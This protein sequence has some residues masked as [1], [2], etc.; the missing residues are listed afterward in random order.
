MNF[1]KISALV[2][3][4]MI[5]IRKS[6]WRLVEIF[7]FP[8]T[9]I[10]IWGFFAAYS[11][12]IAFEAGIF[13]LIVN[14]F[15]NFAYV[16][17]STINI[18]LMD[19]SWNGSLKQMFLSGISEIE[20]I[21]ARIITSSIVSSIVLTL[22]LSVAYLFIGSDL[23]SG[24]AIAVISLLTL[25]T[26]MAMGVL[27]GSLIIVLG[28]GYGFLAWT[29]LQAFI[30]LSAPFFPKEMFPIPLRYVT[31]VM[32]YTHIFEAARNLGTG[33]PVFFGSAILVTVAYSILVW[34][35]YVYFFRLARKNGKLVRLG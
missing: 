8:V 14:V 2:Y 35:F 7:Y 12:S 30:L 9:T 29:A 26:S 10:I 5:V 20:Y 18:Q 27:I 3:R 22:L 25:V 23:K 1:S 16:G 15:W 17:Q 31:E 21:V 19:D 11:K 28:R 4:D 33:N 32:P 6:K 24:S 34:P 13:V